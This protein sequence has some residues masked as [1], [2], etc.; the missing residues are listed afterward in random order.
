MDKLTTILALV[1]EGGASG[2]LFDKVSRLVRQSGAHVEL[3]LAAPSD[4]F[5]VKSG[6]RSSGCAVDIGYTMYDGETSLRDAV[7]RRAAEIDADLLVAPRTQINLDDCPLPVLLLGKRSWSA[8]PRIAAAVDVA[9]R[10]SEALTRGILHVGGFLA[11]RFTA[12]LDIL[13]CEREVLDERLRMERA[14]K[15]ARLV[16]EYYV[17][18]ERLQVFNGEPDEILPAIIAERRY[19][20]LILGRTARHRELLSAFQSVSRQLIGSTDGDLLLIDPEAQSARAARR[21]ASAR[22]ELAHEA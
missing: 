9:E 1:P 18:C 19:D 5:A 2:T 11:Q 4:Y 10:D 7:L 15:L 16:R 14:V 3:F 13:Y 21:G 22:E 8:E 20:V 17:G 12:C 6:C